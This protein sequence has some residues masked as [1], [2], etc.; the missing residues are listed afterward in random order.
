LIILISSNCGTDRYQF[1]SNC[2]G[3][4]AKMVS[5]YTVLPFLR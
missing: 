4:K 2:Y 5:D 3:T 1:F